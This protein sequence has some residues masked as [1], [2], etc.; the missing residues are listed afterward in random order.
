MHLAVLFRDYFCPSIRELE[1]E[2]I[3]GVEV[4]LSMILCDNKA[5]QLIMGI[6]N[7]L[8]PCCLCYCPRSKFWS[9]T[10]AYLSPVRNCS[11]VHQHVQEKG[12]LGH[13]DVRCPLLNDQHG[14]CSKC[15]V[16]I[17]VDTLHIIENVGR[18]I[19]EEILST[20]CPKKAQAVLN[21]HSNISVTMFEMCSQCASLF[22]LRTCGMTHCQ[23]HM[24][25]RRASLSVFERSSP[26]CILLHPSGVQH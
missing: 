18:D 3:L 2:P 24:R 12:L 23:K 26:C 11:T 8:L 20:C 14:L 21:K 13:G 17:G 4:R 15:P 10:H 25:S 7:R 5:T 1:K 9:Y 6:N 19:L 16:A 22:S